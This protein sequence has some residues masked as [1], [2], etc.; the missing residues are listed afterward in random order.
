[1]TQKYPFTEPFASWHYRRIF[2]A[3]STVKNEIAENI[4]GI[5]RSMQELSSLTLLSA[6]RKMTKRFCTS[7]RFV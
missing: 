1:M 6:A 5:A 2:S 4:A 3:H 7:V